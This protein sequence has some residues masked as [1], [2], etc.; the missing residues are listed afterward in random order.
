MPEDETYDLLGRIYA[1]KMDLYKKN[2]LIVK[3][4]YD[5]SEKL[6]AMECLDDLLLKTIFANG[7][8]ELDALVRF[9]Y[10][11]GPNMSSSPVYE[12]NGCDDLMVNR[13]LVEFLFSL[14]KTIVLFKEKQ[15][16]LQALSNAIIESLKPA[17]LKDLLRL[18]RQEIY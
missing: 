4:L 8:E 18:F 10:D 15:N 17:D 13:Q 6:L 3:Q 7:L 14:C 2:C 11:E 16:Y 5:M 9:S 12:S 1:T